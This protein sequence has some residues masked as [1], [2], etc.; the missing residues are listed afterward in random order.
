MASSFLRQSS[1]VLLGIVVPIAT[2]F[3]Q[4]AFGGQALDEHGQHADLH[5]TQNQEILISGRILR[6]VVRGAAVGAIGGAV[7]GKKPGSGAAKGA[8]IGAAIGGI[9]SIF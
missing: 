3:P 5:L 1:A 6:G 8:G 4:R 7:F 2:F 9:L